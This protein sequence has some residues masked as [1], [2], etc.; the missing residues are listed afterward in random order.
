MAY[1]RWLVHCSVPGTCHSLG[2]GWPVS[3]AFG[4]AFLKLVLPAFGEG[5][6]KKFEDPNLAADGLT[7]EQCGKVTHQN[8]WQG[9]TV[10]RPI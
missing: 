8:T 7:A 9:K 10:E 6:L 3:A 1:S 4:P 5:L 2:G